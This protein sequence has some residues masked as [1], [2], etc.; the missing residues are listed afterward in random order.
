[1]AALQWYPAPFVPGAIDGTGLRKLLGG[2]KHDRVS[3]LI[4]E[5]I[6]NS[7]DASRGEGGRP[8]RAGVV[9]SFTAS[10]RTAS[11]AE[12]QNL[13][14]LFGDAPTPGLPLHRELLSDT[15]RLLEIS[16]RGTSGLGGP[17]DNTK[18]VPDGVPTD[19]IDLVFNIG[20]PQDT[21]LG[22]GT[23]GFGKIASYAVSK[24]STVLLWTNPI[25]GA[26]GTNASDRLIASA[27]GEGF[28]SGEDR[29]TGRHWW[30][31]CND[32]IRPV[33]GPQAT[34]LARG[35]FESRF[36]DGETGTS[37]LIL[38]PDLEE[39]DAE[40]AAVRIV[41]SILWNAWP[42]LVPLPGEMTCPMDISVRLE[43]EEVPV[44]DPL[45]TRPFIGFAA[46]LQ[47]VR[48]QQAQTRVKP[49]SWE[50]VPD[51]K[52]AR[53]SMTESV[54][55]MRPKKKVGAICAV[56]SVAI[57]SVPKWSGDEEERD[58]NGISEPL[59]HIAFMRQAE[60]VVK[61]VEGPAHPDADHGIEWSG[62][63]RTAPEV[64]DIFARAEPPSHDEWTDGQLE[65]RSE[66]T[67]L[68]RGRDKGPK[69]FFSRMFDAAAD[70]G[71]GGGPVRG[72][73]ALVG[74]HRSGLVG[75]GLA[76]SAP[77]GGAGTKGRKARIKI[78]DAAPV[79]VDGQDMVVVDF[80]GTRGMKVAAQGVVQL[81]SGRSDDPA[82]VVGF[83]A[84]GDSQP[85]EAG[86][87]FTMSATQARVWLR[88]P[89]NATVSVAINE[90]S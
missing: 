63:F 61:Y 85:K 15:L 30:G 2:A 57:P 86:T 7:W 67:I 62:V 53:A 65:S 75:E 43:G 33:E 78:L 38:Q 42:K 79:T 23:Y 60:L 50:P 41:S 76:P 22:G 11:D 49:H 70:G 36:S 13:T 46:A 51:V 40:Q 48:A 52:W 58:A 81:A 74:E 80:E 66:K 19:F 6:Q 18:K 71:D 16:D 14:A 64:D 24:A 20:A 82:D 89:Q 5:T 17:V 1:M 56:E 69:E 27:I 54:Q 72:L 3:L 8:I 90:V 31:G 37:I 45:Q 84:V 21:A 44:P 35:V 88:Q 77:R 32:P 83:G 47:E 12:R 29:Y 59:H 39:L 87:Q 28:A 73:A 26:P 4:R 34:T 25:V 68:R 10:L 9:P 55:S